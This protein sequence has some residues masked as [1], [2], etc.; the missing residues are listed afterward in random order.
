MD[1]AELTG[2]AIRGAQQVLAQ[3]E[4]LRAADA[5]GIL[6][7]LEPGLRYEVADAMDDDRLADVIQELSEDDQQELLAHLDEARAA[8]ILEAMDPDDA[9]DLLAEL[10]EGI[11]ERLLGLMEPE[12]SAPVRRLLQ[13][14][15]E[16]AGGLMTPEP[17]VLTPDATIAEALARIR[18]PD[19]TPALASMVFVCR[20]PQATPTG[21]YLGCVHTQRLLREPPFE[22]VAG[23]LDTEMAHLSPDSALTDVTR[24]FASYNLVCAPVVDDEDHLLGAVTVDDVLDH[25]LPDNWRDEGM[26]AGQTDAESDGGAARATRRGA[27]GAAGA[28]LRS[29][30][31]V[32]DG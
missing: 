16:S 2:H 29:G 25:L 9:A 5:A 4:R 23:A 6:R 20:P 10:P 32:V 31:G 21:R 19:L 14:S 8:D 3:L 27:A 24:F 17:V 1:P 28:A 18:S 13:Y 30:R 12:E 22:L 11:Q 7:D 15:S 26:P